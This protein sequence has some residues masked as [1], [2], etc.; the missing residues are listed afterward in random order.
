V[1]R[2]SVPRETPGPNGERYELEQA[3]RQWGASGL[4]AVWAEENTRE[5]I[6]DALRRKETFATS[7][8]RMRVRLFAGYDF[9]D[10]L[11]SDPGAVAAAYEG[12]VPMGADLLARGDDSPRFLVWAMRDPKSAPL[13]RV[14]VIKGWVEGGEAR[15]QVFD[16]ACS[17]RLQPD[18]ASHRCPD[19]GAT[20]RRRPAAVRRS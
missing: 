14:Q 6:F 10:G 5:S 15:E 13:Q 1:K 2:G 16:V 3:F 9:A 4:A 20:A 7:G 12:G 18:P 19:N 17:D 11:A 8:P